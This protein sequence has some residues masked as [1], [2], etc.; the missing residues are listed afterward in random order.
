MSILLACMR[1]YGLPGALSCIKC[2]SL[3]VGNLLANTDVEYLYET[4]LIIRRLQLHRAGEWNEA[5]PVERG[6]RVLDSA[7]EAVDA[8]APK[9]KTDDIDG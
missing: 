5:Q 3:A 4:E 9:R 2:Q 7:A 6:Q 1:R 8:D